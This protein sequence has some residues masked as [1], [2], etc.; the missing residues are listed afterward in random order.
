MSG[1]PGNIEVLARAILP[2]NLNRRKPLRGGATLIFCL[3]P[4]AHDGFSERRTM[5]AD[6]FLE[7]ADGARTAA[8][9]D[10]FARKLWRAHAEGCIADADAEAASEAPGS[11]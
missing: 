8:A 3:K 6:Q 1:E 2:E 11:P 4:S 10:E 9:L 5:L 7:A